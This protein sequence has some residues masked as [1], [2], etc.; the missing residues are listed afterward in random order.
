MC[1]TISILFVEAQGHEITSVSAMIS[2]SY[3]SKDSLEFG[4]DVYELRFDSL[5]R[6]KQH[7]CTQRNI[8]LF[9]LEDDSATLRDF[10]SHHALHVDSRHLRG[11][12]LMLVF[13]ADTLRHAHK[14]RTHDDCTLGVARYSM[15]IV[16][17]RLR[18]LVE[19]QQTVQKVS[20]Q[21]ETIIRSSLKQ[22]FCHVPLRRM[23]VVSQRDHQKFVSMYG[24]TRGVSVLPD[25]DQMQ[26]RKDVVEGCWNIKFFSDAEY[27][28]LDQEQ[29]FARF[30]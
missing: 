13:F 27:Q 9:E 19:L 30:A 25:G 20:E 17:A 8:L 15:A 11:H 26:F 2:T 18:N 4:D 24:A 1:L 3:A 14:E 16:C 5:S 23:L 22:G 6:A 7:S 28:L 12:L 21:T 29:Y 10:S